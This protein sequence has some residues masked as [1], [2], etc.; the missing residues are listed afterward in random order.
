MFLIEVSELFT[1]IQCISHAFVTLAFSIQTR[2]TLAHFLNKNDT[3]KHRQS[4]YYALN[5]SI[6]L[7]SSFRSHLWFIVENALVIT[8]SQASCYLR[9]PNINEGGKQFL[10]RELGSELVSF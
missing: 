4:D 9:H 5:L 8:L 6:M 7:F 2:N 3:L 1:T 10:K